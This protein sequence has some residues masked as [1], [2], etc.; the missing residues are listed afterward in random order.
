MSKNTLISKSSCR[1]LILDTILLKPTTFMKLV[2][3]S[4][5]ASETVEKYVSIHLIENK[6]FEK[7]GK[8]R[9]LYS[10]HLKSSEL[11]FYQLMLNP[12]IKAV[13]LVL[14]KS[15]A[16]SQRELVAITDK[17][18][19]SVSRSLKQLLDKKIIRRNY[20][21]PYSTYQIINKKKLYPIL[22]TTIPNIANNFDQFD[23]CYPKPSLFL[24]VF[25]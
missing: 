11:D 17:S 3:E 19:P 13:V 22:E 20:H 15:H 18:N 14:L 6:I 10:P 16:L 24:S 4:G 7:K 5:C 25:D 1:D 8:F 21:A 9:I 12:T 2:A 23:L